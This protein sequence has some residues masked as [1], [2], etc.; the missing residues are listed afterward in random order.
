MEGK[1]ALMSM[2]S[3]CNE[4]MFHGKIKEKTI[5]SLKTD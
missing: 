5:T 4:K 2:T 1:Y 3:L